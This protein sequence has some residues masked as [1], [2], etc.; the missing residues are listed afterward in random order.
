M[1]SVQSRLDR[2]ATALYSEESMGDDDDDVAE[3]VAGRLLREL[4]RPYPGDVLSN[5]GGTDARSTHGT[6]QPPQ[7]LQK[8]KRARKREGCVTAISVA[9]AQICG[10]GK[11]GVE[12]AACAIYQ[13]NRT[14]LTAGVLEFGDRFRKAIR[15]LATDALRGMRDT[16]PGK[17][18]RSPTLC[19]VLCRSC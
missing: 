11:A 14:A 16:N 5:D 13:K 12:L 17:P 3:G 15:K 7:W 2:T 9:T 19:G 4:S 18:R 8:P 6:E 10:S 1:P